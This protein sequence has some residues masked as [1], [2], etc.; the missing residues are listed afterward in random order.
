MKTIWKI[1]KTII[2]T[3]LT[4]LV[5]INVTIFI[6]S[7]FFSKQVPSIL[8]YKP[9]IVMSNSMKDEFGK[10]DLIISKDVPYNELEKGD[11]ISFRI[12]KKFITTHRIYEEVEKDGSICFV[13]KGDNNNI[14]DKG[15][16]CEKD[17]EG[18][19]IKKI[20]GLGSVIAFIQ[21][22]F[23]F[24][25]M[26]IIIVVICLIIYFSGNDNEDEK[27]FLKEED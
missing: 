20:A 16:V 13:T 17:Y 12:S 2:Y 15:I 7:V 22:P 11:I 14:E 19:Y 21:E 9:F 3:I 23:G 26:M 18:K 6:K 27:S 4:I 5:I 10:G 24:I 8:G 25:M 1:I